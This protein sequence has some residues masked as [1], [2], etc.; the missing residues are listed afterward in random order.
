MEWVKHNQK[1]LAPAIQ[2]AAEAFVTVFMGTTLRQYAGNSFWTCK[3]LARLLWRNQ[4]L[5][6]HFSLC[7]HYYMVKME[8]D[9]GGRNA[10]YKSMFN[11][12]SANMMAINSMSAFL[13]SN[14]AKIRE[15]TSRIDAMRDH[16]KRLCTEIVD[17][18]DIALQIPLVQKTFPYPK[19]VP[20]TAGTSKV[21]GGDSGG[22][23]GDMQS[24]SEH[25]LMLNN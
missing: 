25:E 3:Y 2:A 20:S 4:E 21:R 15:I 9:R 22:A 23:N 12:S 1:N 11:S 17:W 16:E 19:P 14:M 8:Q 10:N 6:P 18:Y 24:F 13:S 7:L 5:S